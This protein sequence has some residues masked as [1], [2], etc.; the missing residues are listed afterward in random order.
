MKKCGI[1]IVVLLIAVSSFSQRKYADATLRTYSQ[2]ELNELFSKATQQTKAGKRMF[3]GGAATAGIG[4]WMFSA[5]WAGTF[6]NGATADLGFLM[7]AG[8]TASTILGI[9][10]YLIGKDRENRLLPLISEGSNV[11]YLELYFDR[12]ACLNTHK[13]MQVIA[14]RFRF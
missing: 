4:L 12:Q 11:Q 2:T 7:F 8:G 1:L 3:W 6:G 14:L 10:V 9:P 13:P 5:S